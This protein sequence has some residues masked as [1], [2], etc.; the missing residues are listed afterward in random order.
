MDNKPPFLAPKIIESNSRSLRPELKA[1]DT[2]YH[3]VLIRRPVFASFT[4]M[5]LYY[6]KTV[7]IK[8]RKWFFGNSL[9]WLIFQLQSVQHRIT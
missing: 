1:T 2:I 4:P 9:V 5:E 6:R 8:L 3:P 7:Q